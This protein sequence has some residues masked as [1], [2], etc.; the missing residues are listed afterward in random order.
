MPTDQRIRPGLLIILILCSISLL[1]VL[2]MAF[3]D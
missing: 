3:G 2:Y 1:L